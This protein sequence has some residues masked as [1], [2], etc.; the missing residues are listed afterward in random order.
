VA[1]ILVANI[2]AVYF[3]PRYERALADSGV[4]PVSQK[5]LA[6][7]GLKDGDVTTV[8]DSAASSGHTVTLVAGY[9]DG[10]R[11][12]LFVTFDGKGLTG[13][14]KQYGRSPNDLGI[15]LDDLTLSDQFGHSYGPI[16]VWGPT[17]LQFQP[18]SWPASQ[19]GGRLT[20]H[21]S[22]L[23]NYVPNAPLLQGDWSLHAALVSEPAHTIA[24]PAP[25][26]TPVAHY[27]FT[28]ISASE[29][30]MV[31]H[32]TVDGP[33]NDQFRTPPTPG[34]TDPMANPTSQQYF[35]PRVFDALGK[36]LQM[37]MWGFA[38]PKTGP[39]MGEMTVFINGPGRYRI[40]LG[41]AVESRWVAVP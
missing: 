5:F 3:A 38:W 12:V 22:A 19:V 30:E 9:A 21:I 40:Q 25:I 39:A 14:P 7:V 20:L 37:Q 17:D 31:L 2:V 32:W 26:D 29:T 16:G 27:A 36:E 6:A 10:L 8:N 18:L 1:A 15:A 11:T 4:G 13:D 35:T 23:T 28:H 33:V 34:A 24:V 41:S